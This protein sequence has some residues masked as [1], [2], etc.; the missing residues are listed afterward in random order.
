MKLENIYQLIRK[1]VPSKR[2][3]HRKINFDPYKD[4]DKGLQEVPG[5]A[6]NVFQFC[7]RDQTFRINSLFNIKNPFF[8]K[9]S[10]CVESFLLYCIL[11]CSLL[12]EE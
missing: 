1:G 5:Q 12:P 2:L 6:R 3:I 4:G 11:I 8:L 10:S 7:T 9:K